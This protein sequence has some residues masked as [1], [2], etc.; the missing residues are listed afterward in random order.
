MSVISFIFYPGI[1]KQ[2]SSTRTLDELTPSV[3]TPSSST[4]THPIAPIKQ[5]RPFPSGSPG[6]TAWYSSYSLTTLP[7]PPPNLDPNVG[8]LYVHNN[9]AEASYEVW[10]YS[11]DHSW[12]RTDV[13]DKVYHPVIADRVLSMRANGTPSWITAASYTTIKGRKEKG[14][15]TQ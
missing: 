14:R 12:M 1:L 11:L 10:L 15:G 7:A 5:E 13:G 4:S 8:D 6:V 2:L 9:R 3:V